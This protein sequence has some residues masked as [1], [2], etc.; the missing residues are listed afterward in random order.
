MEQQSSITSMIQSRTPTLPLSRYSQPRN[1]RRLRLQRRRLVPPIS[2]C[3]RRRPTMVPPFLF[4]SLPTTSSNNGASISFRKFPFN[5]K[6]NEEEGESERKQSC[7]HLSLLLSLLSLLSLSL[8]SSSS[9]TPFRE[10][11]HQQFHSA[12]T[13]SKNELHFVRFHMNN[14]VC[15]R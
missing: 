2:H 9:L 12:V 5:S 7:R 13:C 1:L 8:P 10:F 4:V 11:S 14:F 15:I 3:L 6:R